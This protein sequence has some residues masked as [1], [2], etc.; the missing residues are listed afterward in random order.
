MN[1]PL[2]QCDHCKTKRGETLSF[3]KG[4]FTLPSV[5]TARLQS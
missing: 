1:H 2:C 5:E 4:I 3:V